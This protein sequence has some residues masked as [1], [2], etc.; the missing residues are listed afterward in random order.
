MISIVI[1]AVW[2]LEKAFFLKLWFFNIIKEQGSE[3]DKMEYKAMKG[4]AW[5]QLGANDFESLTYFANQV[6]K[7]VKIYKYLGLGLIIIGV[8]LSFA[9]V[10]IPLLVVGLVIYFFVYK[11]YTEKSQNFKKLLSEDPELS[12]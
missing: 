3:M 7:Q 5:R 8:P 10:G 9:F 1:F 6:E 2:I 4:L 12:S 11:K